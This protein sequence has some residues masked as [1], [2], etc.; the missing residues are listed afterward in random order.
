MNIREANERT[1]VAEAVI[2]DQLG[3]GDRFLGIIPGT[4]WAQGLEAIFTQHGEVP[5]DDL[6]IPGTGAHVE[7]H[8]K[9]LKIGEIEGRKVLVFG[10]V[11][12]NEEGRNPDLPQ[13]MRIVIGAVREKLDGLIVTNGVGTLHGR[14]RTGNGLIHDLV[15]EA[16]IDTIGWSKRGRRQEPIGVG[17]LAIVDDVITESLGGSTPLLAG[18]FVDFY[19]GGIHAGD[20]IYFN[21]AR[22]AVAAVQGRC[23]RAASYFIA[24][25]QFEGP[26]DKFNARASGAD[27]IGMSGQ[28][29]L[30]ARKF[31]VPYAHLVFATNG[32]FGMHSHEDNQTMGAQNAHKMRGVLKQL[33]RTWPEKKAA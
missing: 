10:R 24:G 2:S 14:I 13:A 31:G 23:P 6:N 7:G 17:D 1:A 30:A 9:S 25:P 32:A 12:P 16:I 28:E 22:E 5:Y 19:H 26:I 15:R 4:G 8:S 11:H 18:E 33:A 29:T 20:D 21:I 27:V 3:G